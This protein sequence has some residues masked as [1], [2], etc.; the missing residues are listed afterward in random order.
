ML[1]SNKLT[2]FHFFFPALWNILLGIYR[3]YPTKEFLEKG[4]RER[5]RKRKEKRERERD[6][7]KE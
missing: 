1:C 3:L 2:Q 4:G 5:E 6:R 7:G